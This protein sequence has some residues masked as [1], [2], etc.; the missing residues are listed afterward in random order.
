MNRALLFLA[1]LGLAFLSIA[2]GPPWKVVRQAS[3]NPMSQT[4]RFFL[5]AVSF[6]GLSVGGKSEQEWQADKDS[7][8]QASWQADKAAMASEFS[9][10]FDEEREGVARITTPQGDFTIKPHVTWL[11]PGFNALVASHPTEVKIDVQI[12]DAKGALVDEFTID[13]AIQATISNEA[14]GTRLREAGKYLGKITA[15]YV[16]QRIGL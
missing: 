9:A 3:P 11:E 12:V 7:A 10:A 16:K 14:L 15:K 2:C 4:S 5:D 13:A 1:C 6:D 8:S